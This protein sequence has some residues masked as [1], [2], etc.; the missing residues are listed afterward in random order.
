MLLALRMLLEY[1]NAIAAA[2]HA[3]EHLKKGEA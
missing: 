1:A 2:L 3:L